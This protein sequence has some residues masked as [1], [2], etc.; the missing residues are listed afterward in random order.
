MR[1][2]WDKKY[3]YWGVTAFVVI[4]C[5]IMFYYLLFHGIR[6]QTAFRRIIK[7]LMPFIYGFAIAYI[8]SPIVNML[9]AKALEPLRKKISKKPFTIKTRK[10]I[11]VIAIF[12]TEVLAAFVIY[13]LFAMLIPQITKSIQS[14]VFQSSSYLKNIT[15]WINDMTIKYPFLKDYIDVS[16]LDLNAESI[17]EWLNQNVDIDKYMSNLGGY[18]SVFFTGAYG[19][20]RQLFNFAIGI[21]ISVYLMNSKELF[22]GQAKK[23][24]YAVTE[25]H[26]GNRFIKNMRFV[27]KTFIGFIS[28]KLVDSLIIG[29]LCFIG[30]TILQ[31]PY[32]ILVSVVVG[33]TNVIPFFGPY[34][35]AI[36]CALFILVI[37]P[38]HCLYFIIF[39]F[40]LQQ[41]DG[42]ILGPK[43]LG[44][45]TG[46]SGIWVIFAITF[47]GGL[48]GILGMFVGVPVFAVIFAFLKT[49]FE[50]MLKKK[51]LPTNTEEYVHAKEINSD[52]EIVNLDPSETIGRRKNKI[53]QRGFF[54]SLFL[55]IKN[56]FSRKNKKSNTKSG[57]K[58]S[59]K[60]ESS[61]NDINDSTLNDND[62]QNPEE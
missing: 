27:H 32:P 56:S 26:T 43:I 62:S 61:I 55:K 22:A 34:L 19:F 35:G 51:D 50:R 59:A 33:V 31:I 38:I 20:F 21:I 36:P 28:G 10:R 58:R 17:V 24:V 3:L 46:L 5:S 8:L 6:I 57:K 45:S 48:W 2:K 53:Q 9:E 29:M 39:I 37:S 11:R 54:V 40:V 13:G 1:F 16:N 42:N 41:F 15:G 49:I 47:F 25:K 23:I 60:N 12:I 14:I 52:K 44:D 7:I 30:T 4:C 18:F